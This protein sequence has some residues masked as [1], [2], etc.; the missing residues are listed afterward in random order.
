MDESLLSYQ[1]Q[2]MY[3][4]LI[5]NL[6]ER[7]RQRKEL[8]LGADGSQQASKNQQG[9]SRSSFAQIIKEVSAKYQVDKDLVMAVIEAESGFNPQAQSAAGAQGLM[10]LMPETAASLGVTNLFDPKQNI[11][12]GVR[13]LRK[14]LDYYNGDVTKA[15]AGYN[16][17]PGA[18]D[19]YDGI[20]PYQ[21]TQTY[22]N[23]VL[24]TYRQSKYS[25]SV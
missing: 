12:G 17:G 22:V 2:T 20:P 8:E 9:S 11:E 7:L 4:R 13:Y 15:L 5:M 16:A 14:L 1:I 24:D 18:V 6:L 21:E 3:F 23:R 25:W 19:Q 10:Q